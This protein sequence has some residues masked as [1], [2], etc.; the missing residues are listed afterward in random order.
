MKQ[1]LFAI[2]TLVLLFSCKKSDTSDAGNG[3]SSLPTVTTATWSEATATSFKAGGT[4]SNGG[5]PV[6]ARGICWGIDNF[7]DTLSLSNAHTTDGE[8]SGTFE[9]TV[10]GLQP[11]TLYIYRAYATTSAGTVYGNT[12]AALTEQ[13]LTVPT[14]N[15]FAL[16][17]TSSSRASLTAEITDSGHASILTRGF[18]YSTSPNPTIADNNFDPYYQTNYFGGSV[19]TLT[20]NTTYYFRAFATNSVGT[21][22]SNELSITIR[23]VI[24]EGF[25]GGRIFYINPAGTHG[26]IVCQN[27]LSMG[28]RWNNTTSPFSFVNA[29]STS[30]GA[31]N[32]TSIIAATGSYG[33][34]AG[35][36]RQYTGGGYTDWYLPAFDEMWQLYLQRN[37]IGNFVAQYYW[38]STALSSDNSFAY[39][40]QMGGGGTNYFFKSDLYMVRAIRA[41]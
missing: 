21:G 6:T 30:N 25:G 13:Q 34:A 19:S 8:G 3:H 38:T 41:F 14:L 37:V 2:A 39:V 33:N 23:Y 15:A 28:A 17:S 10:T 1:L 9:S 31:Q 24:G 27:D 20:V 4:I 32:T 18:C 5:S 7:T 36:C 35:I 16:Q 11:H 29:L 12:Y 22:Y 26:L 40:I